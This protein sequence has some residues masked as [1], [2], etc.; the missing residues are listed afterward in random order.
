MSLRWHGIVGS[1]GVIGVVAAPGVM[2]ERRVSAGS[3]PSLAAAAAPRRVTIVDGLSGPE[4]VSYD[5]THGQYFVSTSTAP[6]E[7]R[8]ATAS[9]A[10]SGSWEPGPGSWELLP[11]ATSP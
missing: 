11:T 1:V 3:K 6:R 5:L 2:V 10:G 4:A 9:S 7:S 8:T